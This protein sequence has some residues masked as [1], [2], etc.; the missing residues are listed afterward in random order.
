VRAVFRDVDPEVMEAALDEL[1]RVGLGSGIERAEFFDASVGSVH[2]LRL[3]DGRRVVIKLHGPRV[4]IRFL[5]A[6]Q[7]VQRHLSADGF[8]APEPLLAPTAFGGGTAV[9]ET[10]LDL[11]AHAD[12]RDPAIRKA[13]AR[14]LADFVARSRPL[15]EL[16]DLE[17]HLMLAREGQLWPIPHDGRFDLQATS[18]GAEWIDRVAA[19]ALRRRDTGAGDRVVGHSDWRVEHLRFADGDLTAVY[20]W[21]SVI[22]EREPI[23]VG[24]VAHAFTA[25]WAIE[26]AQ[27]YP[28]VE[29]ALAF[30]DEYESARGVSFSYSERQVCRAAL[31]YLMAY[32]ARCEHS[33][34]LL[35]PWGKEAAPAGSARAFVAD[36]ASEL[37]EDR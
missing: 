21:D 9:A 13:M 3:R 16:R 15:V 11:G 14:T 7:A 4:T 17:D 31:V 37:L 24:S 30:I 10:L 8:P 25:N 35:M 12:G 32:A 34:G 6:V 19:E 29:E 18:A 36:H 20:D 28:T 26:S 5:R 33:D 27:Q 23:L 1:C 22:I 2:G